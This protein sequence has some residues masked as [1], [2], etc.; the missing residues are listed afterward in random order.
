MKTSTEL[1]GVEIVTKACVP[2]N[3]CFEKSFGVLSYGFHIT[4]CNNVDGCN[5][6]LN[7]NTKAIFIFLPFLNLFCLNFF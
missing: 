1:P 7:L 6:A 5:K 2:S 3:F 4:C